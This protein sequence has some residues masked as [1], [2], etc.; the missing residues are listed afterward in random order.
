MKPNPPKLW[1]EVTIT[2]VCVCVGGGGQECS[3]QVGQV[4]GGGVPDAHQKVLGNG[5]QPAD[6][7]EL[8]T[9]VTIFSSVTSE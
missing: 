5:F 1:S 8:K 2:K 6:D 3:S 7:V 4:V 9:V